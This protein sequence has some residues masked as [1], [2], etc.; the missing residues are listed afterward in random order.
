MITIE[1][2]LERFEDI[3]FGEIEK[4]IAQKVASM[5]LDEKTWTTKQEA[6]LNARVAA[7]EK[8]YN[9]RISLE[10]AQIKSKNRQSDVY[11]TL[12]MQS[13]MLQ[14][15]N[16]ELATLAK[17]FIGT[18]E[19]YLY[20]ERHFAKVWH[21][22]YQDESIR[23]ACHSCDRE[24]MDIALKKTGFRGSCDYVPLEDKALG[25]F[26]LVLIDKH[27]RY[28]VTLQSTILNYQDQMAMRLYALLEQTGGD[29]S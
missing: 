16:R 14:D 22:A 6:L 2:K 1:K 8:R 13:N 24:F 23:I 4:M 7:L 28:D 26:I 10:I 18:S 3:V 17:L 19:Y 25:G 21:H 12:Q 11:R 5:A 20:L 9:Q 29:L 27:E 15:L